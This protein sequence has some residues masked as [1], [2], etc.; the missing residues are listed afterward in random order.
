[1]I[2]IITILEKIIFPINFRKEMK[3]YEFIDSN[4][5]SIDDKDM[6]YDQDRLVTK[7]QL[8]EFFINT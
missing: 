5:V 3:T 7:F 2:L 1:M 4:N 6:T 8:F